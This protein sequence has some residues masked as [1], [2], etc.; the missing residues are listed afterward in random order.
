L[1]IYL[2]ALAI[3]TY[4]PEITLSSIRLLVGGN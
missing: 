1:F 2:L 4:I 3:I